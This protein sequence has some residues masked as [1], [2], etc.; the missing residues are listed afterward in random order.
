M[1]EYDRAELG[2]TALGTPGSPGRPRLV[3]SDS[4][5]S[6]VQGTAANPMPFTPKRAHGNADGQAG[7]GYWHPYDGRVLGIAFMAK[8]R[9]GRLNALLECHRNLQGP[10]GPSL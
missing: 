10:K 3:L 8:T 1:C 5:L 9:N 2:A 6:L 7:T 4:P